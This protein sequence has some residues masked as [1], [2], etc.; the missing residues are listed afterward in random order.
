LAAKALDL[1]VG[2]FGIRDGL[3][4]GCSILLDQIGE[5]QHNV[6]SFAQGVVRH[7]QSL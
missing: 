3:G 2:L 4:K 1:A 5:C 7:L 6:G